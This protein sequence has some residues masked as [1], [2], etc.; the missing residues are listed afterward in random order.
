MLVFTKT[1]C[2]TTHRNRV[3]FEWLQITASAQH[4]NFEKRKTRRRFVFHWRA[5]SNEMKPHD[6]QRNEGIENE[7]QKLNMISADNRL[8][9]TNTIP[10]GGY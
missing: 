10:F 3:S 9:I 1:L 8:E 7:W 4:L 5:H 2:Q 6:R